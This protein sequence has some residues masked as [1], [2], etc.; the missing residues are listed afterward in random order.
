[1][2]IVYK[3]FNY[4]AGRDWRILLGIVVASQWLVLGLFVQQKELARQ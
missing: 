1:M 4:I 3:V 2:T